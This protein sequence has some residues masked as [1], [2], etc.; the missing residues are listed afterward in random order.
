M[1]RQLTELGWIEELLPEGYRRKPMFG[2][3]AYYLGDLM[4]LA[5]F[6][7]TGSRKY[8]GQTYNFE[9]WYGCM[10]PVERE[11]QELVLKQFPNLVR[12]PILGKWLYLPFES[13]D[14]ETHAE[15]LL[16][17]LR[18]EVAKE[19][20][21]FGVIP[22]RKKKA[23]GSK[24]VKPVKDEKIDTRVPMMFRDEPA[25]DV[26][27]KAKKISDLRNLGPQT[28]IHFHKAGIKSVKAFVKM[29]WRKAFAK[30]VKSNPKSRHTLYAYAL[31]GA[32]QNKDMMQISDEDK[33]EAKALNAALKPKNQPKPSR[34]K[35]SSSRPKK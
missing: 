2:G 27:T 29:G 4:I 35:S 7:S 3:F 18:F 11:R 10:F 6:E 23:K 20:P 1:A 14:F 32:L 17:K 16:K 13:E 21:L 22:D 25:E 8:R 28:E 19:S 34:S 30:L 26:L 15:T 31:I 33:A 5:M 9:L 12:H 24:K